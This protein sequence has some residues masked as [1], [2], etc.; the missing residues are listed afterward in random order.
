[1]CQLVFSREGPIDR[2]RGR[3]PQVAVE[4][5]GALG[6]EYFY[7]GPDDEF[8]LAGDPVDLEKLAMAHPESAWGGKPF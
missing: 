7:D 6:I 3:N 8:T 2:R 5:F 4:R 1:M